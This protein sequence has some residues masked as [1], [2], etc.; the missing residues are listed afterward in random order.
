MTET[1][2]TYYASPASLHYFDGEIQAYGDG[3]A[4][5]DYKCPGAA[6]IDILGPP[7]PDNT[8]KWGVFV[9][10]FDEDS[11][12]LF[13]TKEEANRYAIDSALEMDNLVK[14]NA[15]KLELIIHIGHCH[16]D[17]W[18]ESLQLLSKKEIRRIFSRYKHAFICWEYNDRRQVLIQLQEVTLSEYFP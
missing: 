8:K 10:S 13:E 15:E 16:D 11:V 3:L 2:T 6:K 7:F 17:N 4:Y 18:P 14:H 9:T 12:S 1:V 5:N